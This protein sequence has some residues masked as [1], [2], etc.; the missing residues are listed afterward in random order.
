MQQ[1]QHEE[2]KIIKEILEIQRDNLDGLTKDELLEV[3]KTMINHNGYCECGNKFKTEEEEEIG[4]C[5]DCR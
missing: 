4:I 1:E 2:E 5:G 3:R